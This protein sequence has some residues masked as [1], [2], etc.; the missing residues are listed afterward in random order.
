MKKK[1]I[2]VL[3]LGF[4]VLVS[5]NAQRDS[6]ATPLYEGRSL[7]IGV[8]GDTPQVG[9]KEHVDFRDITFEQLEDPYFS[10]DLDAIF[11]TKEHL[12]KASEPKYTEIYQK[13]DIPFFFIESKKSHVPFTV[14][15][16]SYNEV[17]DLSPDTY[18]T[19]FYGKKAQYW[20]YGLHND[21]MNETNIK[22]TYSN[23]F[24]IIESLHSED[25]EPIYRTGG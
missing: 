8:I 14:K 4:V 18:V 15:E 3:L 11:I 20:D 5:G 13:A 2:V 9:E 21:A 22:V 12:A 6:I 25:S 23:I 17:P 19:G 24:T 16:L 7:V 10:S 1:I